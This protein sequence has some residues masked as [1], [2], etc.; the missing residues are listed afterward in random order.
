MVI[1][2][3]ALVIVFAAG[4]FLVALGGASLL[5]PSNASR[6]LL[7]F[8]GSPS[9]HFTEL[10]LRLLIGGAFVLHAPQMLFPFAFRLFGC[11][12]LA[13]TAGLLLIPWRW[14]HSFARRMVPEALRFLPLLGFSSVAFGGLILLA[15]FRGNSS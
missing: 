10:A 13:T 9:K 4:L 15:V 2:A 14:H 3:T 6:F 8:A 11:V 7:G 12:L 5:V 1:E